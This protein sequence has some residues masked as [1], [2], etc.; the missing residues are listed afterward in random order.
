MCFSAMFSAM[1]NVSAT[2]KAIRVSRRK[3]VFNMRRKRAVKDAMKQIRKLLSA[4][5]VA[6]AEKAIPNAQKAIDKAAK[7]GVI[8]KNNAAR[9]KSRLAASIKDA[10]QE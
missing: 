3:A 2:K 8:K 5:N 10:K 1:A 7:R 6:D 9:K 4:G